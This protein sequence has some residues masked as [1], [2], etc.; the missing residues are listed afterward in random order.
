[1]IFRIQALCPVVPV[2]VASEVIEIEE[3]QIDDC[4]GCF[5]LD[6]EYCSVCNKKFLTQEA[7]MLHYSNKH[8]D[9]MQMCSE[10]G[11]LVTSSRQMPYHF[12]TKHPFT[13]IPLYLKSSW[14]LCSGS[15]SLLSGPFTSALFPSVLLLSSTFCFWN[16]NINKN[17]RF[18]I[19]V[20]NTMILSKFQI[21]SQRLALV[22]TFLAVLLSD[23]KLRNEHA[24][25]EPF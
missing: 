3:D 1:M 14:W 20:F 12:K 17:P 10:C 6:F 9:E 5:T 24:Y 13:A 21:P 15:F 11:M 2:K 23:A 22:H 7:A 18:L 4:G 16:E 19:F 8:P 25:Y